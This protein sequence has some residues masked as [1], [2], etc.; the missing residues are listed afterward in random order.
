MEK[1]RKCNELLVAHEVEIYGTFHEIAGYC[2]EP[3]C[4]MFN[5]LI[6]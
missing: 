6:R 1:C 3:E 5:I 2:D 4:E